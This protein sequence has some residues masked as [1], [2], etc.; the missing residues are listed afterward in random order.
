M[1]TNLSNSQAT[2][3]G[4]LGG[5]DTANQEFHV[6]Y[7]DSDCGLI[8][9]ETFDTLPEAE[10]FASRNVSDEQGW[11]V[12]DAVPAEASQLAA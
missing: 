7:F 11:A 1:D 8:R 3:R 6:T 12:I 10:R 9:T 2:T 4:S 5:S